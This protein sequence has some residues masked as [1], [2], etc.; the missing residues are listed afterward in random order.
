M[1]IR[2]TRDED[3]SQAAGPIGGPAR[4]AVLCSNGSFINQHSDPGHEAMLSCPAAWAAPGET[5]ACP[6]LSASSWGALE[7]LRPRPLLP[8]PAHRPL[9]P[10]PS[11]SA[12]GLVALQGWAG[13][14]WGGTRCGT[15]TGRK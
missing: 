10:R 1:G 13:V 14:G 9:R 2:R 15:A 5:A 7:A 6:G 11:G 4:R 12:L 8:G 3:C